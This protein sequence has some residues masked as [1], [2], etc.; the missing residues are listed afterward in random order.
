MKGYAG[1]I[2]VVDLGARTVAVELLEE[3]LCR[4]YLGGH[5]IGHVLALRHIPAGADPL[6]PENAVILSAGLFSGTV[7]PGSAKIGAT[8]KLPMSRSIGTCSGSMV[9]HRLKYAGFDHVVIKGSSD[10]PVWLLIKDGELRF[11]DASELWGK[12][13]PQTRD[14]LEERLGTDMDTIA[15]GPAGERKV[16][17]AL[18]VINRG[19]TLGRG[20]LGAVLGAKGVK[21]IAVQG[22]GG[23]SVHNP[24]GF[25]DS[26]RAPLD[27]MMN[28]KYRADW[29][30]YGPAVTMMKF[31]VLPD[32]K[33]MPNLID[34]SLS[35]WGYA[36]PGCPLGE[37][38]HVGINCGPHAGCEVDMAYY[39]DAV[40]VWASRFDAGDLR[41]ACVLRALTNAYGIDDYTLAWMIERL[42]NLWNSGQGTVD[43]GQ[44]EKLVG[45]LLLST[46]HCLLSTTSKFEFA[47]SL[48]EM[49]AT[50]Q[51][52]GD[53]IAE[54]PGAMDD[55]FDIPEDR[56]ARTIKGMDPMFDPRLLFN[57]IMVS[58]SVHPRGSYIAGGLGPDFLPGRSPEQLRQYLR[59]LRS[60]E[61]AIKRIVTDVP[62]VHTGRLCAITENWHSL[63]NCLGV[64]ARQPVSQAYSPDNIAPII[65]AL[66]GMEF[67]PDELMRVGE[68]SW[69][70][71]RMLNARE[72]FSR[73]DDTFPENFFE[74][75]E[76]SPHLS[77]RDYY[78]KPMTQDDMVTIFDGYYD[79]KGW[80]A[81]TGM[82][83]PEKLSELGLKEIWAGSKN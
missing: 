37:K 64:C 54:G 8:A 73:R 17:F 3:G 6:G 40:S 16:K 23:V 80:D 44:P 61:E 55:Y 83:T 36:C 30:K 75:Q 31:G 48:I 51:G 43:S 32:G 35:Y 81:A 59:R 70:L 52:L 69:N 14:A 47:R 72:G 25:L 56:R 9:S 77:L 33:P 45:R 53:I 12:T 68:R 22:N 49:V 74:P 10:K 7:A 67:S 65:A 18:A 60:S 46:V 76:K 1:K 26:V 19:I 29:L 11:E 62:Y 38:V 57:A 66:T 39:P 79:E 78:G 41:E 4:K 24:K 2:A 63:I 82:P 71:L 13:V 21:A 27:S 15:I 42:Y 50:R 28:L 58:Q 20:G 5:G 34:P